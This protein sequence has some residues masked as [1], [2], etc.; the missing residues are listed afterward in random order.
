MTEWWC[1]RLPSALRALKLTGVPGRGVPEC[2]FWIG[3][4][5]NQSLSNVEAACGNV[6]QAQALVLPLTPS[7]SPS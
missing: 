3:F 4:T 6:P 2:T 5:N 1:P 7:C